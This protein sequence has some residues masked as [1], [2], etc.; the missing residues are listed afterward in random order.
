MG[1]LG[2]ILSIL[3][4]SCQVFAAEQGKAPETPKS[5][6]IELDGSGS[7]DP[8]QDAL[9]YAWTQVEGPE[10]VLSDPLAAKPYFRTSTPG[11]Y[12]FQLVVSDGE[13]DSKPALVRVI[14]E[15]QNIPPEALIPHDLELK[16]GQ[17]AIIDGSGS[18]DADGDPLVFRWRHVSGPPLYLEEGVLEQPILVFT[19]KEAGIHEF[20]L[21]VY[22][23]H[24]Y[25]EPAKCRVLITPENKAPVACAVATGRAVIARPEGLIMAEAPKELPQAAIGEIEFA[26]AGVE[27][28][29]DGQKS[30]SPSGKPLRYYWKQRSGPFVRSFN[31]SEDAVLRFAPP[32]E[33]EY[34]FEL[35]VSDGEHDSMPVIE[36]FRV[37]EG[38]S[39]P[40][41]VIQ[42]PEFAVTGAK[43][44]LNG[45][46]SFDK[47]GRPLEYTWRQVGGPKILHYEMTDP[48]GSSVPSFI[49]QEAG[50]YIF[51]LL[52][53]DGR[54]TSEPALCTV[55]VQARNNPPQA[56]V[57]GDLTVGVGENAIL[58]GLGSDPDGDTVNYAWKQVAGPE[59]L[60]DVA[61]QQSLSLEPKEPGIY[62]FE[63]VVSDGK[64]S[65]RPAKCKLTVA[66]DVALIPAKAVTPAEMMIETPPANKEPE[67]APRGGNPAKRFFQKLVK[68]RPAGAP[69]S[70]DPDISAAAP[71]AADD[72]LK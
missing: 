42:A 30:V 11:T 47:E 68:A 64:A 20:D 69:E 24:T 21:V 52:V 8:E 6:L 39:A 65:S 19:P 31:R 15:R 71:A 23:G 5:V 46:S 36:K 59:L 54:K 49:P 72:W 56:R 57:G 51:E 44:S 55:T 32:K 40:I 50:A 9:K 3:T 25:S 67:S 37:V 28:A 29:L 14:V 2:I 60:K 12:L 33:G 66:G 70:T 13:I 16:S 53:N 48:R 1:R 35:V 41:A 4:L 27:L 45:S 63:L 38:N 17:D 10:V 61:R 34:S 58:Q 7:R 22:D 26:E 43:V 62:L 18:R